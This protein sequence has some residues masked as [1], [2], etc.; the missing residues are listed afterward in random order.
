MALLLAASALVLGG[1]LNSKPDGRLS[2]AANTSY[3][4]GQVPYKGG[5]I[6]TRFPLNVEGD[7]VVT[8]ITTT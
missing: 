8:D 6:T 4:F 3:D 2:V 7:A 5:L 1:L